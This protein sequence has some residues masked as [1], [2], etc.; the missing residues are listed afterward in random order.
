MKFHDFLNWL[1]WL[2]D[3]FILMEDQYLSL[4]SKLEKKLNDVVDD[5]LQ[6]VNF[7]DEKGESLPFTNLLF[8]DEEQVDR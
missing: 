5:V 1:R 6:V 2:I 8:N 4:R 3:Y 7:N